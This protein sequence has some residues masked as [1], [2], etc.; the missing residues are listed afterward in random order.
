VDRLPVLGSLD[1]WNGV[2]CELR[3]GGLAHTQA[4]TSECQIFQARISASEEGAKTTRFFD[5]E[6]DQEFRI[7]AFALVPEKAP[8]KGI[9][10]WLSDG[11]CGG[12]LLTDGLGSVTDCHDTFGDPFRAEWASID[13][14]GNCRKLFIV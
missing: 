1:E 14:S 6:S 7:R 2:F 11:Y 8:A 9:G 3:N 13:C 4:S 5:T 10:V 12:H